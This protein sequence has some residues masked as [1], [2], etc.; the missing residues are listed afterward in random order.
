MTAGLSRAARLG[1]SAAGNSVS[2]LMIERS[3]TNSGKPRKVAGD[4]GRPEATPVH[5]TRELWPG[6][7]SCSPPGYLGLSALLAIAGRELWMRTADGG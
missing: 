7:P 6:S 1:R 2:S 5:T 4:V 3:G